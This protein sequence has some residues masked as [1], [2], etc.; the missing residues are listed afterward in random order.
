MGKPLGRIRSRLV[1]GVAALIPLFITI[2]VLRALFG[3]TAGI[4]LPI[5]DPAVDHWP[6]AA[7]VALSLVILLLVVY[8]LGELT[9]HIVGRRI[10][11]LAEEILLRVP[12]VRVIYK[13]SRQVVSAFERKDRSAFRSVVIVEFPR[14]GLRSIGFVT[15]SFESS[16]GS[17]WRTVFVPTT[18]N[19]TTGFLQI[20]P[21]SD[22]VPTDFTVEEAFQMVMS[23]GVLSP[24]RLKD[25]I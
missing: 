23:L 11:S 2:F 7:R 25:V 22:V 8:A 4:I 20:L 6:P 5:L 14:P 21:A 12:L 9:A 15:S 18:P 19:P 16:D 17:S 10:I 24:G 3:F 13:A 1:S